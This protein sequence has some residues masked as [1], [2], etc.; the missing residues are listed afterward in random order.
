MPHPIDCLCAVCVMA[1]RGH[2]DAAQAQTLGLMA[3]LSD[4]DEKLAAMVD[5]AT[6]CRQQIAEC[7]G[8]AKQ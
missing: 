3:L 4:L 8:G 6:S 5:V 2:A 7:L 1:V